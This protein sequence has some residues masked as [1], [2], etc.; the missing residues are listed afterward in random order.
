MVALA[1][2]QA[3]GDVGGQ[4]REAKESASGNSR[5]H[6]VVSVEGNCRDKAGCEARCGVG[7]E[8]SAHPYDEVAENEEGR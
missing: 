7:V 2:A 5:G 6:D 3:L 8:A 1:F 4:N